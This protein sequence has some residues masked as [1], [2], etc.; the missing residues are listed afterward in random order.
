MSAPLFP[1]AEAPDVVVIGAG[2]AGLNA[3]YCIDAAGA[4]VIV[5]EARD[6]VGGRTLTEDIGDVRFDLGAQWTGP[7]Q[8]RVADLCARL[9][10]ATFPTAHEGR[11]VLQIQ[12]K[13]STYT[14]NIPSLPPFALLAL[15]RLMKRIERTANKVTA[16]HA[17]SLAETRELDA[18]TVAEWCRRHTKNAKVHALIQATTRV[19]FG[20]DPT[21]ISALH[22]FSYLNAGGG[23][24]RLIAID[25]GAQ[26]DRFVGGA[27]QLSEGLAEPMEDRVVLSAPVLRVRTSDD[28]V[29]IETERGHIRTG[30]V[31]VA[32]PPTMVGRIHFDPPLPATRDQLHQRMPMGATTKVIAVYKEPFWREAGLSGEAVC[33]D[34]PVSVVFDNTTEDGTPALLAFVVGRPAR[35]WGQLDAETRQLGVLSQLAKWFGDSA[36]DPVAYVEKDWSEDPWTRG[37]PIG[38]AGPDVLS[39]H[40]PAL[41]APVGRIHWAGTETATEWTGFMEGALQSGERA[42]AEVLAAG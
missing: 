28:D 2:L 25:N 39:V 41:R 13:T 18:V 3:A 20:A 8:Y 37:C 38:V 16:E 21:E 19:V 42:A 27:Q 40:G 5:L 36:M 33:G 30:R 11:K 4:S 10:V 6:R 29:V 7:T 23:L 15:H 32:I 12:S 22:F 1:D 26:Q 9:G 24:E 14:S 34:G 17:F 31:I 35:E